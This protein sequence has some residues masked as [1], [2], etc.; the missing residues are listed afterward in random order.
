MDFLFHVFLFN[1]RE[2][3]FSYKE[4][5]FAQYKKPSKMRDGHKIKFDV[6]LTSYE[7]VSMDYTTLQSIDWDIL[8][9]DEAHRLKN[10]QSLVSCMSREDDRP[11][12]G[13]GFRMPSPLLSEASGLMD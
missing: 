8:I 12:E 2:Y 1:L 6:L 10:Q 13:F 5:A 4:G 11:C 9:I 3:E 7:F